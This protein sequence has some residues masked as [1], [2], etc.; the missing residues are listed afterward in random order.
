MERMTDG[1]IVFV[2]F[3]SASRKPQA[4]HQPPSEPRSLRDAMKALTDLSAVC[5][6]DNQVVRREVDTRVNLIAQEVERLVG[7]VSV[8]FSDNGVSVELKKGVSHG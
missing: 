8:C 4:S 1:N 3:Q 5:S 2:N 7:P 6:R